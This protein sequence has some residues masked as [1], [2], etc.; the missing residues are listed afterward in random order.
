LGIVIVGSVALDTVETPVGR[1]DEAVGGAA[2]YASLAAAL[3]ARPVAVVGVVGTDFP[4]EHLSMLL[5]QGVDIQGIERAEGRTFRWV[6][7]YHSDMAG[8]DTLDTQLNVFAGFRPQIPDSLRA[9]RHL[10]LANIQPGLQ[11]SVL[12][13]MDRPRLT[14]LDTMNFWISGALAELRQVMARVDVVLVNDEEAQMLTGHRG[15]HDAGCALLDMGPRFAVV[16]KGE[17]G[18]NLYWP[19]GMLLC[20]AYPVRDVIDPTGA[21]DSFA[22]GLL[23]SLAGAS[24]VSP[25]NLRRAMAFGTAVASYCV[26]GFGV[27]GLLRATRAGLDE[28]YRQLR[29][30]TD[31]PPL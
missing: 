15:I 8:R 11:L 5:E 6:G 20:P 31:I 27:Q 7:R 4:D 22:G 12:D 19:E 16:K 17:H 14:L 13:Q 24:T 1:V 26:E 30:L 25:E 18:A 23:G 2:T 9:A 28:R 29:D 3:L 10:F 21:G